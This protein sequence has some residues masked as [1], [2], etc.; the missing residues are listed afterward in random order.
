MIDYQIQT[1][2]SD[3]KF[4]PREVVAMAKEN[5]VTSIA[6]TDHDTVD[7]ID[8]ALVA[9]EEFGTEVIPGIEMSC[10]F[11]GH[12]IHILGFGIRHTDLL[13]LTKLRE[14][15]S[16]RETRATL[17]IKKLNQY[18]F[19]VD[20][21]AVRKRALGVVAR[22]H[23]AEAVM[24]NPA[25]QQ[26]LSAEGIETRQDFFTAYIADGAKAYVHSIPLDVKEAIHLIHS[27]GGIAVWSHPTIPSKDYKVIEETLVRFCEFGLDGIEAIGNFTEDDTKFLQSLAMIYHLLRSAGSD[28]HDTYIDPKKS[29]EGAAAIGGYK[30]FGY[31]TEGI[32]ESLRAA[33]EKRRAGLVTM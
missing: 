19:I 30:T 3:G 12:G 14:L 29:E 25:N 15:Q 13:L 26:K 24:D 32:R 11:N 21:N 2:A 23:I 16:A 4:S 5:D 20:F 31:P 33:I 10:D 17:I 1:T 9:G 28:F 8:E 22:P 7:G 6:I 27:A 18:G